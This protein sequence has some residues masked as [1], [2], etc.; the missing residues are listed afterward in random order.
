MLSWRDRDISSYLVR[1][2]DEEINQGK[3]Q[4]APSRETPYSIPY[5]IPIC[6]YHLYRIIASLVTGILRAFSIPMPQDLVYCPCQGCLMKVEVPK[7]VRLVHIRKY[8]FAGNK[9]GD[10]EGSNI[11]VSHSPL[12]PSDLMDNMESSATNESSTSDIDMGSD[13]SGEDLF[14]Y[15]TF[16]E[17][18]LPEIYKRNFLDLAWKMRCNVSDNAYNQ[19]KYTKDDD[20]WSLKVCKKRLFDICGLQTKSIDRCRKGKSYCIYYT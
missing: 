6:N 5:S 9:S 14:N 11:S 8:G 2:S 4:H 13:T 7:H 19:M 18:T 17:M 1:L 3:Q 20:F 10:S 12:E 16:V 15:R